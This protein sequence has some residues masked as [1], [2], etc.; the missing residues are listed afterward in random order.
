MA[1]LID[2]QILIWSVI[3][4]NKLSKSTQ[5]LLQNSDICFSQISLFEVAIK[6][7]I[8]KLPDLSLSIS[9]FSNQLLSDGFNLLPIKNTHIESYDLIPF[10]D[11]HKDPFDRLILAT[12]LAENLPII[13]ADENFRLYTPQIR[14]IEN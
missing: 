13:S 3:S 5:Q 7:K 8:G 2:T 6:Q 11:H 12:A 14:L 1:Y 10:H 4:K 9:D